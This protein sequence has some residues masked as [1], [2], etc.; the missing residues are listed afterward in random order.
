M[1]VNGDGKITTDDLNMGLMRL[2]SR[3]PGMPVCEFA[4]D[5]L[6]RCIPGAMDSGGV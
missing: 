4:V 5:E 2:D 1:L 6:L 3:E